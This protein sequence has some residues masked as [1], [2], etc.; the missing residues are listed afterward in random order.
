MNSLPAIPPTG[1][2]AHVPFDLD[3]PMIRLVRL[4][5]TRLR[6]ESIIEVTIKQF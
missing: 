4:E 2:F 1:W 5:P 3:Q 6:A